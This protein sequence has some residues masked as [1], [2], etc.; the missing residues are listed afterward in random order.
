M[1]TMLAENWLLGMLRRISLPSVTDAVSVDLTST[2]GDLAMTVTCSST[3]AGFMTRVRFSVT[4]VF[5][6]IFS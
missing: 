5:S 1:R 2:V 6:R 4:V 3:V